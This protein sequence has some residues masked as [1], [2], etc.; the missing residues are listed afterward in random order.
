MF[1]APF[2]Q[3]KRKPAFERKERNAEELL[4]QILF[5]DHGAYLETVN[6]NLRVIAA[7]Y[8]Q[9]SGP[10]REVLRAL[11]TIQQKNSFV[12]DWEK[13]P[14]QVYLA[15]YDFLLW[16]LRECSNLVNEQGKNL[17]FA[18]GEGKIIVRLEGESPL[19]GQV[20]LQH[21]N[22]EFTNWQ[23]ISESYLLSENQIYQ[24]KPLGSNFKH[25]PLFQASVPVPDVE[26]YLSL[27][28]SSFPEV[29]VQY[30]DY[31]T[32]TLPEPLPPQPT[33]IFEKIDENNALYLR[34][35]QVLP[36]FDVDFLEQYEVDKI[37][38]LNDLENTISVRPVAYQPYADLVNEVVSLVTGKTKSKKALHSFY[39][40]D[41]LLVIP[42]PIA[43]DFLRNQLPY[44]LHK[45][46]LFGAEKLKSYKIAAVKPKLLLMLRSSIDFLEGDASL[47]LQGQKFSLFDVIQQY[48]KNRYIQLSDGTQ[49]ILNEK[50][51]QRL[52]R[53]FK[54][55]KDK[56]KLSFFD[57]P[58]VEEL[59]EEK[60]ANEYF[61]R[62]RDVFQ[63][64]NDLKKKKVKL[65]AVQAQL[66]PYQEQ[67]FK[68][69]HYLHQ[70]QLGGCLADD[71]GLGKTLQ[72]I[73]MLSTVYPAQQQPSL[74][75]M[76]KSLLFNWENELRKFNPALTSYTYYAT[77]RDLAEA[78]K[79][80]LILTTYAILRNDIEKFKEQ[81]F[82]YTI[83]D[84]SQ[85][86]KNL[87]SQVSKAVLLLNGQHRLA[88]SGT[89]VENNLTELYTLFRY[90]NPAMFGSADEFNRYYT[91]PIQQNSD[92][93]V[94]AELRRKV[95]P[96][97][98]RRLKK[99]VIQELPSK[100]EQ[101]LFV[102]MAEEQQR[103]YEERRRYYQTFLK[104]QIIQEGI[105]KAQ[106]FILQAL[107]E[108]RQIASV[109]E[110]KS[111]NLVSSAKREVLLE[112]ILDAAAN[113]HKMLVFTNFLNGME[114]IGQDL[115]QAGID[116]VEM[117][118]STSTRTRQERVTR[119][120]QDPQCRVF[121]M[122]LKTGG[123][124]LN[125]TA[126]DMVFIF[127][128]WWNT[129][130]E[131]QAIDRA[132]RIGQ[133]K[134]VFSYRLITKNTI[135]EKIMHLQEKKKEL[136]ANIIASDSASIKS[137]SET[138]IEFMLGA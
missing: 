59:L 42:E 132:H 68:W 3:L 20:I 25:L 26:K 64:F 133:D 112:N 117:T 101:T 102:E 96:F 6:R 71:M 118:G 130:A 70:H 73:T 5:D 45:Y 44:L 7:D 89:P 34:V 39:Q 82:Y 50:Y 17:L 116:F 100:I 104:N 21:E 98:L 13:N 88:L 15:D 138:D 52:E 135:E 11:E 131:N 51:I 31:Q 99:D 19:Q 47:E 86:A 127:D 79:H 114:L 4:F 110:S 75:V 27:L 57:L 18:P 30:R 46:Q 90:L 74:I 2:E 23:L 128:P 84:E 43:R 58:L 9:Y 94:A 136:F 63:G 125:L 24:V 66:R 78:V 120:Q 65:P 10:V 69:L 14:D 83:L 32:V 106:F 108:L 129:A 95:Y 1:L 115:N 8:R 113:G 126:A 40:E 16:Q 107:T 38:N 76:P 72:A 87:N 97:I 12:I 122:T 56:V 77:T 35:T 103:L 54:K 105:Q 119:F 93:E 49:A 134:T 36:N 41:N 109:P 67:G 55:K 28:F 22:Q 121:L 61:A 53:L 80:H 92:K 137:L 62:S 123:V 33:L 85:N 91:L 111:D 124:G 29:M 37:V 81:A 60:I 48:H